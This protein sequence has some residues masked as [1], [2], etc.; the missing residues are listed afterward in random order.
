MNLSRPWL[1]LKM[2]VARRFFRLAAI[3]KFVQ[4]TDERYLD[5][6]IWAEMR[7]ISEAEAAHQLELGVSLGH[8]EECLLYE[9]PDSPVRFLV[10]KDY[11][12]RSVRL[13]DIGY[14]GEDDQYEVTISTNRVR[15]VF[16]ANGHV[17]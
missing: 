16:V 15:P 3:E 4:L 5:A 12:G 14:I 17:E 6:S 9:W 1:K 2:W 13:A 11:L 7:G 8:L 10:P